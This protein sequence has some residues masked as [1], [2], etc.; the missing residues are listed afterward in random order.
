[1]TEPTESP[2]PRPETLKLFWKQHSPW[3]LLLALLAVLGA[4][5]LAV[6]TISQASLPP[7]LP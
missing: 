6:Y 1:M 2:P 4:I 5:A 3:I 7:D